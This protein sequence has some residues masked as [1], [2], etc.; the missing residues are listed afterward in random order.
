MVKDYSSQHLELKYNKMVIP[1]TE[2]QKFD[3]VF[4]NLAVCLLSISLISIQWCMNN[5]M[6]IYN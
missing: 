1:L 5:F 2:W 6:D 3:D 4:V